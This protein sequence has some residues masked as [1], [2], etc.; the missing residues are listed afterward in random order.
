MLHGVPDLEAHKMGVYEN[1][2]LRRI[3][4]PTTEDL[5]R[6]STKQYQELHHLY[7]SPNQ[8]M[9]WAEHITRMGKMRKRIV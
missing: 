6:S 5:P 4:G 8:G 2:V 9:W 7:C 1:R 3:F